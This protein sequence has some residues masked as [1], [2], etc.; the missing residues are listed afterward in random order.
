MEALPVAVGASV[1]PS[2]TTSRPRL[3]SVQQQDEA[4]STPTTFVPPPIAKAPP[5][6]PVPTFLPNESTNQRI[7]ERRLREGT[8]V[9]LGLLALI[10]ES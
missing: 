7:E 6:P 8:D 2:V 5:P 4:A 10:L 3:P 9:V 1:P